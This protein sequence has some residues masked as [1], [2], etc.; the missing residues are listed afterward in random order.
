VIVLDAS[1]V[2][3]VLVGPGSE[4]ERIRK[5]VEGPGESLHVP[6]LMDL[7]VLHALRRQTLLGTLSQERGAE[8]LEDLKNI[9]FVRYPHAS[10]VD[11]IWDLKSNL[12]AYDAAYVALA[13]ALGA[14]LVTLDAR[15]ARAPGIRAAVEVY[16]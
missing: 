8:A 9:A 16:G 14:P 1:A 11:R 3:A 7:E 15:L 4:A 12:T 13:E 10:L 5:K 2:V 6:H